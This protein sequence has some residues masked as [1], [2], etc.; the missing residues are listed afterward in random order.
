ML[1]VC[2][3][4]VYVGL[5]SKLMPGTLALLSAKRK[6]QNLGRRRAVPSNSIKMIKDLKISP[7]TLQRLLMQMEKQMLTC[8]ERLCNL[9]SVFSTGM[10]VLHLL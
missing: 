8:H 5:Q 6:K 3:A 4:C 9:P 7:I 2:F 10:I 1:A